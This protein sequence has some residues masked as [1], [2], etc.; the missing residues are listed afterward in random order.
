MAVE[1]VV[2]LH[3]ENIGDSSSDD[4]Q[5]G[6]LYEVIEQN[7]GHGMIRLIDESGED[8]LYPQ[9]WFDSVTLSSTAAEQLAQ[10]L[11]HR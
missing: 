9:A 11:L 6:R 2:C 8:Y 3:K 5:L 7:A 10:V 4:L 1:F